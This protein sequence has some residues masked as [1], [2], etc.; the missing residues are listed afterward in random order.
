LIFA[1]QTKFV[2]GDVGN[3]MLHIATHNTSKA[4]NISLFTSH[5]ECI[6]YIPSIVYTKPTEVSRYIS[7]EICSRPRQSLFF[8]LS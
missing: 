7:K 5:Y 2:V 8:S 6:C 4:Y 1:K 3:E